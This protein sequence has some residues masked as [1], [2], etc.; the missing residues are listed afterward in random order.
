MWTI[1]IDTLKDFLESWCCDRLHLSDEFLR[2]REPGL[3]LSYKGSS[4][5]DGRPREV[6]DINVGMSYGR[7]LSFSRR[8]SLQFSTGST[9]MVSQNF[10]AAES[11]PRARFHLL[12]NAVLVHEL[13]APGRRT[14]R[15][16]PRPDLSRRLRRA[17]CDRC[18][19]RRDR[20]LVSRHQC[21]PPGRLVVGVGGPTGPE[22]AQ[23]LRGKRTGHVRAEP[24][25]GPVCELHL[26][27]YT[28]S[29]RTSPSTRIFPGVL[30]G[31][32]YAWD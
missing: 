2:G 24:I 12:G 1:E 22:P 27:F 21:V 16:Q 26:L 6:H 8:T 14:S 28:S 17:V 20:R 32:A 9:I 30:T 4:N 7:A 25:P 18:G 11:D 23:L 13:A 15:M 3:R 10:T 29:A 31:R 19:Q 5:V